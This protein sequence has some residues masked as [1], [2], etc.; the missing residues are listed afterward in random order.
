MALAIE[1]AA[2]ETVPD[3]EIRFPVLGTGF[4]FCLAGVCVRPSVCLRK[5][6]HISMP[7]NTEA[8]HLGEEEEA[9]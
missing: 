3:N 4:R 5:E 1:G 7:G 9:A 2:L 6:H 8:M